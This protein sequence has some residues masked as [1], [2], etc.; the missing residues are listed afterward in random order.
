MVDRI[1]LLRARERFLDELNEIRNS[2][3]ILM[4]NWDDDI[5]YELW[6]LC[7][8]YSDDSNLMKR[9]KDIFFDEI[10]E[11]EYY[12]TICFMEKNGIETDVILFR[13]LLECI[14]YM[15]RFCV[16]EGVPNN[17][18]YFGEDKEPCKKIPSI[19][20]G[21]KLNYKYLPIKYWEALV[22]EFYY[23]K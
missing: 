13:S 21:W 1:I 20:E 11:E 16:I 5:R 18:C 19:I 22:N 3:P 12:R 6:E 14:S 9:S 2:Y 15:I 23:K 4:E 17:P 10:I 8:A 7:R